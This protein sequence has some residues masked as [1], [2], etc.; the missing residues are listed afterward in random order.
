MPASARKRPKAD[1]NAYDEAVGWFRHRAPVTD[2]DFARMTG[3]AHERA[4]M[5]TGAAHLDLVTDVWEALDDALARGDS[6]RDFEEAVSEKLAAAWGGDQPWRV[7]TIWRTNL[8]LAYSR[9]R[10][11]QQSAPVVRELRP[12]LEY[13]AIL[14]TRTTPHC[15]D[16]D[17]KVLR[18]D[19]PAWA[20]H[21]PP[22]HFNCRSTTITLTDEQA[23]ERGIAPVPPST[24]ASDGFGQAPG[25]K[26]W[27][28]DLKKKPAALAEVAKQKL[29]VVP[30]APPEA[31]PPAPGAR[32]WAKAST[33]KAGVEQLRE[34]FGVEPMDADEMRALRN[35]LTGGRARRS[36][37]ESLL[38]ARQGKTDAVEYINRVGQAMQDAMEAA[39]AFRDACRGLKVAAAPVR[40]GACFPELGV[41]SFSR[42]EDARWDDTLTHN[43]TRVA[44]GKTPFG[45][46]FHDDHLVTG[47]TH[48]TVRHE[49]AHWLD[50]KRWT[51][52]RPGTNY[53]TDE[54]A[55]PGEFGRRFFGPIEREALREG[56]KDWQGNASWSAWMR[57]YVSDYAGTNRQEAFAETVTLF[58]SPGYKKGMLPESVEEMLRELLEVKP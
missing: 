37:D 15:R 55:L 20:N 41:V 24:P 50:R 45:A 30:P 14:D 48:G 12:F 31:T 16:W 57:K 43:A 21:T 17:G 58:T 49:L 10:Y 13:S 11:D 7:E 18:A 44:G 5:V 9:G 53:G 8:Q 1:P 42:L 39:P 19:D 32:R 46:K 4:F 54:K 36:I 51:K 2:G 52:A 56:L 3:N 22:C 26:V 25:P 28:P 23:R 6:L 34:V 33:A 40:R 27:K 38:P 35:K 29:E 47:S